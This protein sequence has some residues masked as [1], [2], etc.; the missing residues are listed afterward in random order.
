[1]GVN[2]KGREKKK[3]RE[4]VRVS[5]FLGVKT[6]EQRWWWTLDLTVKTIYLYLYIYI[7]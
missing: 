3:N 5:H 7:K 1:M 2:I 6:R 4:V